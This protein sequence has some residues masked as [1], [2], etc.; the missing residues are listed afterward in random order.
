MTRQIRSR[1][2]R[3]EYRKK[4]S[5]K[6]FAARRTKGKFRRKKFTKK[7]TINNDYEEKNLKREGA[8]QQVKKRKGA[9]SLR[10]GFIAEGP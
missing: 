5:K 10:P 3:T 4:G 7:T 8:A 1:Q 6:T 9:G 2:Y